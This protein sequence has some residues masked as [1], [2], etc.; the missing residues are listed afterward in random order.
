MEEATDNFKKLEV[1]SFLSKENSPKFFFHLKNVLLY[2]DFRK[3]SNYFDKLFNKIS[4][5]EVNV[6]FSFC[7]FISFYF[8]SLE[9]K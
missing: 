9:I 3:V 5:K 2:L 6:T 7:T 8:L 4:M 1:L